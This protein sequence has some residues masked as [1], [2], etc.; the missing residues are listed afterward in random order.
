M[1]CK[2]GGQLEVSLTET[3]GIVICKSCGRGKHILQSK[4]HE[5]FDYRARVAQIKEELLKAESLIKMSNLNK[6]GD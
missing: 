4:P 3:V 6:T 1:K 2:C 5:V